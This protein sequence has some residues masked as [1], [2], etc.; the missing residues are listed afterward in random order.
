MGTLVINKGQKQMN[1]N[2]TDKTN[3][4]QPFLDRRGGHCKCA[5]LYYLRFQSPFKIIL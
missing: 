2:K 3:N 1:S 5:N 4:E